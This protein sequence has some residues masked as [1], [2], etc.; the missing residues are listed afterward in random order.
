MAQTMTNMKRVRVLCLLFVVGGIG[1]VFGDPLTYQVQGDS[2]AII[3][4][5]ETASGAMV[6]PST[7]EGS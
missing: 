1:E 4:C 6:I 3:D 2:V 5:E 7:Y